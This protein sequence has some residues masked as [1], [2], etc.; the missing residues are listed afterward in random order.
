MKN[1]LSHPKV[2]SLKVYAKTHK[3]IST[4]VC[5]ALLV[6]GY[7]GIKKITAPSTAPQYVLT[8]VER[9]TVIA[10]I[11]GTGQVEGVTQLDIKPK[12]SGDIVYLGAQ[13]GQTITKGTLI[14]LID[15]R[16]AEKNV[17]DAKANLESAQLSLQKLTQPAD[18]LSLLQAENNLAQAKQAKLN[19]E[20]NL[21]SSYDD[22]FSNIASTFLD[23][24]TTMQ[25]LQDILYNTNIA[26]GGQDNIS[27]Y[28]DMVKDYDSRVLTYRDDAAKKF[29]DA[30]TA[31]NQTFDAYKLV[32]RTSATS[33]IE[34]LLN[35]TYTTSKTISESVKSTKNLI[36]FVEDKLVAQHISLP[37]ADTAYQNNLNSYTSKISSHLLSLSSNITSIQSAKDTLINTTGS[38]LEKT[39][40]LTKTK[41][42]ADPLDVAG[43]QLTVTQRQNALID[44]EE[45]L[46]DNYIRAQFDGTL[47]RLTVKKG[48]S[49]SSGSTIGTFITAQKVV[50][51]SLNEVDAAKVKVG[52]KA[53]LTFDAIDGLEMTAKVT[54][55]DTIGTVTQGVVTYTVTLTLDTQDDR[56]KSGMSASASIITDVRQDVL[57]VP[58]SAIKSNASGQ[59][60]ESLAGVTTETNTTSTS[61]ITSSAT[62][63]KHNVQTGLANDTVTEII[64]GVQEGD[65]IISRTITTT[66]A[67][68]TQ[69]PSLLGNIGG[70]A[71]GAGT[72]AIQG[73]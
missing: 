43:S 11:T 33:S 13:S 2:S 18:D 27:A 66:T 3:V 57:I 15:T 44:A 65:K 71:G 63:I 35:D 1:L 7:T 54:E 9:G 72:R 20:A 12:V 40:S 56:I 30:K 38:I 68:A 5:I 29:Q 25:G 23:L 48:D 17:R 50:K 22:S 31:Y 10:S 45:K 19:A 62:P 28:A 60:V 61:G 64:S 51:I 69:A 37:S 47:G 39:A 26:H 42:G 59:Y 52:Q 46:A 67:T 32:N 24:P 14:A 53:T 4:V 8:T 34:T 55:V 36:D 6:L 41:T 21:L 16:D 49:V 70:R 73:R 58:N